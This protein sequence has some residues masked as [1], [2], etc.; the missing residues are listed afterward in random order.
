[1]LIITVNSR[2][3]IIKQ[4]RDLI[5]SGSVGYPVEFLFSPEWDGLQKIAVFRGSG[6]A[7]DV[8]LIDS[9]ATV[10]PHEVLAQS[11]KPLSIGV[12]GA[13][14][15]GDIVIPTVYVNVGFIQPGTEPSEVDPSEPTPSWAIQ[16]QDAAAEAVSTA[17]AVKAAADAGEFDGAPGPQGPAGPQGE[18][19]PKGPAG[20]T[21]PAG[22]KGDTG[23]VGPQGPQGERGP[24]GP[25]GD[26]GATGPQGETGPQGP[27]GDPGATGP[28]GPRGPEGPQGTQGP[29]GPQGPAYVLT[30][31]D[32]ADIVDDVLAALPTW[33]GGSY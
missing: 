26:T 32:K 4:C 21:G 23:P 15:A 14:A 11:G 2:A 6:L 29:A 12:Y 18:T 30:A 13:N 33:Q 20:E 25:K 19:G 5:T 1:M 28:E 10:I 7:F 27:K 3:A 31:E 16:V 8:P 22:P 9:D 24:Q 17:N